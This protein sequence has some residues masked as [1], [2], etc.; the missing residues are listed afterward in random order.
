MELKP[1]RMLL[2][3]RAVSIGKRRKRMLVEGTMLAHA[4]MDDEALA[5]PQFSKRIAAVRA[6]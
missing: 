4:F 2:I 6:L 3:F 5:F 1:F